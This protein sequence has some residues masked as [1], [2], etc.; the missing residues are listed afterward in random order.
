MYKKYKAVFFDWDGT[1]V[2]SRR[3]P[4]HEVAPLLSELLR[5]N[6]KLFV[7]S[8]TTCENIAGGRLH[9]A[10][11]KHLLKN[12]YLG[13]ARGAYNYGFGPDG[14]VR[15][16]GGRLPS[17]EEKLKIHV[18]C[19]AFHTM[20]LTQYGYETDIVF[21][22]PNYC[23]IDMLCDHDRGGK[24]FLQAGESGM[25]RD[26]LLARGYTKGVKGLI[27]DAEA[28][29]GKFGLSVKATTDAK[30]LEVGLATKGD[31]VDFLMD[32]TV[33]GSGVI[34]RECCFWGDEFGEFEEGV[35]GSDAY[36]LTERTKEADFFDVSESDEP[37]P[38]GV[39]HVGGGVNSFLDFLRGQA[40]LGGG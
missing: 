35:F 33:L 12:L 3:D 11:P 37:V 31:N 29:G 8:G 9:E 25:L 30:Y 16:L 27:D 32:H 6:V 5:Q 24:L 7:I 10:I 19:F 4:G 38:E 2:T 36:M 34:A 15:L 13:L 40:A 21:S 17:R 20:L 14:Q 28:L 26:K 18:I 22:R 39:R 1:A 23:K